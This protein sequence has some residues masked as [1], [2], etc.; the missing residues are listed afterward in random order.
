M[1]LYA[2]ED[3]TLSLIA[4]HVSLELVECEV[5]RLVFRFSEDRERRR[6]DLMC[7]CKAK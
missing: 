5:K 2:L 3:N 7:I 6:D 4:R 1:P